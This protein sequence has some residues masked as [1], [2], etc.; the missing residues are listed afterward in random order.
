MGMVQLE[1]N[2]H[3]DPCCKRNRHLMLHNI[4]QDLRQATLPKTKHFFLFPNVICRWLAK[5][6]ADCGRIA[7]GWKHIL[8][9]VKR[10]LWIF[11]TPRSSAPVYCS[12]EGKNRYRVAGKKNRFH[13][14][15]VSKKNES[16]GRQ[17]LETSKQHC[18]ILVH[19]WTNHSTVT[20]LK[21]PFE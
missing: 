21:K 15:Q 12:H 4:F 5:S 18:V 1:L 17:R 7:P 10:W 20:P 19:F 3:L 11:A 13:C 14:D 8:E 6:I 2:V 9:A 16:D